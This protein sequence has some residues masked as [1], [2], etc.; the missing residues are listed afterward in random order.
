MISVT[1]KPANQQS[2][3]TTATDKPRGTG[4]GPSSPTLPG[5]YH[6]VTTCLLFTC[7]QWSTAVP[8]Q[9]L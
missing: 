1:Y 8:Y 9:V 7:Y 3:T 6:I 2:A 4:G 5:R